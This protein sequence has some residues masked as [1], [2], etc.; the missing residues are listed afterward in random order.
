MGWNRGSEDELKA[1]SCPI[2]AAK[3]FTN[4]NNGQSREL[5]VPNSRIETSGG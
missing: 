5:V 2:R 1:E 3:T 4:E